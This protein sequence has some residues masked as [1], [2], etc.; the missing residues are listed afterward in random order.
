MKH[1]QLGETIDNS[2]LAGAPPMIEA[3]QSKESTCSI[4][5]LQLSI[6]QISR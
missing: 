1:E 6:K 4:K 3:S 5:E 2:L